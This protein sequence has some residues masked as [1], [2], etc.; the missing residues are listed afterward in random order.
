MKIL[1]LTTLIIT[2]TSLMAQSYERE[3]LSKSVIK[4]V[5]QYPEFASY[6]ASCKS[7]YNCDSITVEDK[8][9]SNKDFHTHVKA[10]KLNITKDQLFDVLESS[11]PNKIWSAD[12]NF[13]LLYRK[14][15]NRL[16]YKSSTGIRLNIGDIIFLELTA[17]LGPL[18]SKLP[19]SFKIIE[20][21]REKGVLAFSYLK[22]NVSKGIQHLSVNA[23]D[24]QNIH[25][26]HTSRYL[27]GN[28]FRDNNVYEPFH[29]QFTDGFYF[30]IEK[31][32]KADQMN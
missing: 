3:K 5:E 16:F 13:Q 21:D 20:M 26:V 19:V 27:S 14:Q 15:A 17:R 11:H 30:E 18:K 12:S 25:I 22:N 7:L 9:Y 10:Y 24:E 6:E 8:T 23:L 32:I 4:R 1:L 29:E 2:S 28:K 31:L